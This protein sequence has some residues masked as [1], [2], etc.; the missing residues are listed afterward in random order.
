MGK[1]TPS[2]FLPFLTLKRLIINP[3]IKRFFKEMDTLLLS[4]HLKKGQNTEGV[5]FSIFFKLH[6]KFLFECVT[7]EIVSI[8]TLSN[9]IKV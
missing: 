8:A 4:N 1:S 9:D 3:I 7:N 5:F 6:R 2:V